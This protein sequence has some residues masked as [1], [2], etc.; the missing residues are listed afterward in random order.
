VIK[1]LLKGVTTDWAQR[2]GNRR[3]FCGWV[4]DF[5]AFVI[6]EEYYVGHKCCVAVGGSMR[7]R[8]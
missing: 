3:R 4:V 8:K 5:Y 2:E 7:G 6:G 1:V